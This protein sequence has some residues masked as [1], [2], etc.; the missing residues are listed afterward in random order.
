MKCKKFKET[1]FFKQEKPKKFL[2]WTSVNKKFIKI[3][4]K[5]CSVNV[6]QSKISETP[7]TNDKKSNFILEVSDKGLSF[8]GRVMYVFLPAS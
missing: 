2:G 1:L 5:L 3:N 4:C 7:A 8:R 6:P